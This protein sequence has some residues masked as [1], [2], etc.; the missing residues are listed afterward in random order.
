M[1]TYVG[2]II[3]AVLALGGWMLAQQRNETGQPRKGTT[4]LGTVLAAGGL[5]VGV[6]TVPSSLP[7]TAFAVALL[8]VLLTG[9]LLLRAAAV[10][11][12][13]WTSLAEVATT[14]AGLAWASPR[15]VMVSLACL[16][17]GLGLAVAL[18]ARGEPLP[19]LLGTLLALAP[20][21]WWLGTAWKRE[22][23]RTG[24]ERAMAGALAGGVEWDA[25]QAALRGAP[26]RVLFGSDDAPRLVTAPLPP[27]WSGAGEERLTGELGRRLG[28]WGS[29][30]VTSVDHSRRRLTAVRSEPLPE[31]VAYS[32][33]CPEGM[34]MPLGVARVSAEAAVAGVG[35]LGEIRPF[36]WD[37]A[38]SPSG[39]IVGSMGGGKSV[40]VR[41]IVLMWCR[42]IGEVYL[43]D[44]KRVEF[45][46]FR[47]RKGVRTVA[48]SL[49]QIAA[50]FA[51]AEAEMQRR[52][53]LMEAAG[54]QHVKDLAD[55]MC[56]LLIVCDEAFELFAKDPG[57]DEAVKAENVLRAQC[58]ASAR[59]IAALG[60][61][62]GIHLILLAQRADAEVVA[63]SLQNN[64]LFRALLRPLSAGST[65][66]NMIGLS[67]VEVSGNPKGRAVMKTALWPESEVQ[68]FYVDATELDRWLPLVE[69][70]DRSGI[71]DDAGDERQPDGSDEAA[72][73]KVEEPAEP[74]TD[75][76]P[77]KQPKAAKPKTERPT[78]TASDS[79]IDP[80]DFFEG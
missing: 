5:L 39:L 19:A 20:V 16:G 78:E 8:G 63:G 29:P 38:D 23:A 66:R 40:L 67:E 18:A 65:A 10:R 73:A 79:E 7:P 37:A 53:A 28:E 15:R 24:V 71:P 31:A 46:I 69:G 17:G 45:S 26:T 41:L 27:A 52:Y 22:T 14:A 80:L 48:T 25:S 21:R 49:E 77:S 36:C 58:A 60:R 64:L 1:T 56:P 76:E 47:G 12:T 34:R 30:W 74:A 72:V 42:W 43:L 57:N 75:S 3:A 11:A 32:G 70:D 54:V 62:A 33:Q 4:R 35:C 59:A 6:L 68:V 55:T 2:L 13:G 61:A 50:V 9:L 51:Q 44:P